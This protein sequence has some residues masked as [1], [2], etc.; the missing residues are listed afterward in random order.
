[1]LVTCS[2][3][4]TQDSMKRQQGKHDG[5]LTVSPLTVSLLTVSILTVT[6]DL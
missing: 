3:R 2:E 6:L 1:M 4:A 5:I